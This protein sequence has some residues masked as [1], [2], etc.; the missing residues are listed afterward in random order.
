MGVIW[1]LIAGSKNEREGMRSTGGKMQVFMVRDIRSK[2][3]AGSSI[4]KCLTW[5]LP[6]DLWLK[7]LLSQLC[8]YQSPQQSPCDCNVGHSME[9][10]PQSRRKAQSGCFSSWLLE[11]VCRR[12]VLF[13]GVVKSVL[14]RSS[15]RN[16]GVAVTCTWLDSILVQHKVDFSTCLTLRH[17]PYKP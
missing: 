12:M 6:R 9:T 14:R 13:I 1:E 16:K 3:L 5:V 17:W 2:F 11:F 15:R 7:V 4:E 10:W 8:F